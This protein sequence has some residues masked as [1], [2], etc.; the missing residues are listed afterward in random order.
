MNDMPISKSHQLNFDI[1]C[2]SFGLS[3]SPMDP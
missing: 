2:K 3:S 1:D